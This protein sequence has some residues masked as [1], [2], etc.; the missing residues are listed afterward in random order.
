MGIERVILA[1]PRGFCAGVDRAIDIV[2]LA[3]ELYGS[4]VYVRKEIVHNAHV[5]QELGGRGAVFVD[6]LEEV[7]DG[8]RVIFSAHGIAPEVRTQAAAKGLRVIDAT[9]PL[10]TKVHYEA[11]KYDRDGRWVILVGHAG[12]D[13][14]IGTM[15]HAPGR[16]QLVGT[17]EE[18]EQVQVSDPDRVSVITQTTLSIDDTGEIIAVL[19]RRFPSAVFPPKDDI[20]YA[21]QNRQVAV[22]QM[23]GTIDLLLV[24]GSPNS[25]NSMRLVEVAQADGVRA[26]LIDDVSEID[27]VWLEG[28]RTVGITAGASAPEHL[29]Q[30][31]IDFFRRSGVSQVEEWDG[32]REDVVFALPPEIQKD[33]P[34]G[35]TAPRSLRVS[36]QP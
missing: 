5:V 21:T 9:C 14:V 16:M 17:V 15:G 12:H 22:K 6:D 1:A 18:A 23:A 13:E 7:P 30:E 8:A 34:A 26:Y 10:V 36:G 19:K 25:S 32:I 27:P 4:P 28:A 24:I 33:V 35:S 2:N 31:A 11:L 29:V 3:L 20:C